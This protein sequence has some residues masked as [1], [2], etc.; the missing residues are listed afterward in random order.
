MQQLPHRYA[1]SAHAAHSGTVSLGSPGLDPI[2]NAA[3]A[4]FGGPGDL[5]S[6]E[7]MLTGAVAACFILTF[8]GAARASSLPW[9]SVE[10]PAEGLLER[11]D[12][13]LQF[14]EFTLRP[15]I[16]VQPGTDRERLLRVIDKAE[17][18]CLVA[19][20]LRAT[21]KVHPEIVE[22]E[23]HVREVSAN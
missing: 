7:T 20:S 23:A 3:P 19:S 12:G 13:S 9:I 11:K 6:P 4:E 17:H 15:K 8:R 18:G 10:C 14:T 21:M 2:E 22:A 5:W 1:V 16:T